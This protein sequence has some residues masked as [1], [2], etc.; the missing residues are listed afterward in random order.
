M[1]SG[2]M[3]SRIITTHASAAGQSLLAKNSSQHTRPMIS[4][5]GPAQQF[6][7]HELA[8]AGE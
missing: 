5:S 3:I 6:G 4:G 1:A 2:T 8:D 7:D